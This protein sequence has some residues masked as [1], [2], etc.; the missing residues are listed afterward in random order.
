M[1]DQTAGIECQVC[2]KQYKI[3]EVIKGKL[4]EKSIA[5][6]IHG[7]HPKWS[8]TGYICL[9]DLNLFR[10]QY[11]TKVL[12]DASQEVYDLGKGMGKS[13]EEEEL[14]ARNINQDFEDSLTLG[15][16]MADRLADFGG[17][18]VFISIFM[19]VL[20][21]WMAINTWILLEK[22]FDPYPYILLN[23]V[24]SCLAAIQAPVILMSQNRQEARDR[25]HSEHDYEINVKA[26]IEIRKIHEKLDHLLMHQWQRLMEIQQLQVDLMEEISQTALKGKE[27]ESG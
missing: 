2:G 21:I 9:A 25:L 14:L 20:I 5:K 22:P 26:E 17:S 15:Q 8:S 23:L 12:K 10:T 24:L 11:V 16:R 27:P 1:E 6:L 19:T 18:W 4:I 13:L 3:G 7:K